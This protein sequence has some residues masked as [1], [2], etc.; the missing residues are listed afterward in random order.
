MPQPNEAQAASSSDPNDISA[1]MT[2]TGCLL[3]VYVYERVMRL[4]GYY[5]RI[6]HHPFWMWG[7]G[8][9]REDPH[10]PLLD[11]G[12]GDGGG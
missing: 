5:Q 8:R 12:C 2:A 7:A 3:L 6:L 1:A 9:E 10:P 4:Y 11:V